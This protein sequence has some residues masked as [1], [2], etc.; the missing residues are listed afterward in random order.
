M[1][2]DCPVCLVSFSEAEP[3]ASATL[4]HPSCGEHRLHVACAMS[5]CQYDVRC[6]VCRRET[7]SLRLRPRSP[8]RHVIL[9][10]GG[11]AEPSDRPAPLDSPPTTTSLTG[12]AR[13]REGSPATL[14]QVLHNVASALGDDVAPSS[15]LF[16]GDEE[17]EER[18]ALHAQ[19]EREWRRYTSRRSRY[20]RSRPDLVLL[21]SKVLEKKRNVYTSHMHLSRAYSRKQRDLL[22]LDPELIG[23]RKA[24]E[25][26]RRSYVRLQRRLD[27]ELVD[28]IGPAP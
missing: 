19:L 10:R 5:L 7:D 12:S 9:L 28:G 27:E 25:S 13:Q 16:E 23:L 11:G 26:S 20:V 17:G 14:E 1:N 8:R 6:P 2:D 3:S 18:G 22:R 21:R 24:Y 15:S 4:L